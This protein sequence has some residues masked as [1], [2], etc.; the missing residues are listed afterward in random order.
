M[1]NSMHRILSRFGLVIACVI[2]MGS[3]DDSG[4]ERNIGELKEFEILTRSDG[5]DL[6]RH[7]F[8]ETSLW[9]VNYKVKIAYPEIAIDAQRRNVLIDMGWAECKS[10]SGNWQTYLEEVSDNRS[11]CMYEEVSHLHKAD[12][13]LTIIHSYGDQIVENYVCPKTPA[14]PIQTVIIAVHAYDDLESEITKQG[15][16][17]SR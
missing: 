11:R 7:H 4:E 2:L 1:I 10:R 8:P 5:I 12:L 13:L 6:E 16:T 15:L 3:C 9:Q 14:N 17:C